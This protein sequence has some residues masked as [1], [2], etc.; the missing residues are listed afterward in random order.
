LIAPCELF[1][2]VAV[3]SHVC[4]PES[5]GQSHRVWATVGFTDRFIRIFSRIWHCVD[6][7]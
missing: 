4:Q 6:R 7:V 5:K 2:C 1:R 3:Q